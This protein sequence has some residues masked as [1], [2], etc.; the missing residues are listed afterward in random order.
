MPPTP[1]RTRAREGAVT[2]VGRVIAAVV[3]AVGRLRPAD[4]PMHPRGLVLGARLTRTGGATTGSV[5]LDEAGADEVL[6]RFSRSLGTPAPWPD[7]NGLAIRVPTPDGPREHADVLLSTTG[8]G[9]LTRYLL[10]PTRRDRGPFLGTLVPY[11]SATGA[12]HLG[13]RPV[14]EHTWD[15][16]WARP[17]SSRWTSYGVLALATD[18][19]RDLAMSFDAVAGGPPGLRVPEWHRRLRGPSYAAA[20]RGRGAD[21]TYD[22]SGT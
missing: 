15:L 10:V 2:G 3:A 11:R 16:V 17:R 8:R 4:K 5:F 18:P 20:R 14:D 1:S 6:V 19:G 9:R 21:T 22:T 12:I 7:V 13:A